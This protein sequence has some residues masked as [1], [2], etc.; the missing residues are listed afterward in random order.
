M[1]LLAWNIRGLANSPFTRRLKKSIKSNMVSCFAIF[2]PKVYKGSIKD[3]ELKFSLFNGVA[4]MEGNIWVFW[5]KIMKATLFSTSSQHVN[6]QME[7]N[8]ISCYVS[9]IHASCDGNIRQC[10][11]AELCNCN[12]NCPWLVVGDFNIVRS[13]E[14]KIQGNPI[15]LAEV[16]DFNNMIASTGLVDGGF[17]GNK[18]TW[19]NNRLG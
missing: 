6:M 13:H 7:F 11:W 1:K 19:C 8:G 15:K 12:F 2:E 5:R 4:N 18:F 3:Y 17:S 9:F 10:L 14:E 16:N